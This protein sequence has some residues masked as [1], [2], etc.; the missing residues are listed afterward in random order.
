MFIFLLPQAS[1]LPHHA[2]NDGVKSAS[3]FRR[4]KPLD[5]IPLVVPDVWGTL[6]GPDMRVF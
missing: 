1:V 5:L 6:L 4:L 3:E 2:G